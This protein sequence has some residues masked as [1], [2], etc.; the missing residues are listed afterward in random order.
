MTATLARPRRTAYACITVARELPVTKTYPKP[1]Q[2][3]YYLK[4][5]GVMLWNDDGSPAKFCFAQVTIEQAK[6]NKVDCEG[7]YLEPATYEELRQKYPAGSSGWWFHC[8]TAEPTEEEPGI[9]LVACGADGMP[10]WCSCL[11]ARGH[12][13]TSSCKHKDTC[14]DLIKTPIT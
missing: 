14:A 9:Y 8:H 4:A 12:H 11:G 6:G 5:P 2:R 13:Q 7:Y 10:V 1:G 3:N